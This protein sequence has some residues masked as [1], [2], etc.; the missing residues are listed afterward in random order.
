MEHIAYI[1]NKKHRFNVFNLMATFLF[2]VGLI[3]FIVSF[4]N[5]LHQWE[6]LDGVKACFEKAETQLDGQL[7][8]DYFYKT[9]GV[10]LASDKYVPNEDVNVMVALMPIAKLLLWIVLILFSFFLFNVGN[11]W[12]FLVAHM[13]GGS[14][15]AFKPRTR[16]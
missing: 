11:R 2:F 7:C 14:A 6:A 1:S 16:L 5:V 9:T 4:A 13:K 15:S 8:A 10:A 3:G 12:P